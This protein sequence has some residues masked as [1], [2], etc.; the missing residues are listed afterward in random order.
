MQRDAE[1]RNRA[2]R[3]KDYDNEAR[4]IVSILC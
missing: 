2:S 4:I 1:A 3:L